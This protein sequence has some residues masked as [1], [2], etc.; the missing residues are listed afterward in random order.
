MSE[1]SLSVC[2]YCASSSKI[3]PSFLEQAH[4]LG[5]ALADR[6]WRLVY[7]AGSSGLMGQVADGALTKGGSVV[8]IIPRFMMELEWNHPH[9]GETVVT[10]T[11][12]ER[13]Q[14]MIDR[15]DAFVTLPGGTG[16]LEEVTECLSF[17]RLGLHNKPVALANWGGYYD[18]LIEQLNRTIDD[19]FLAEGF[20]GMFE[21]FSDLE[22][23]LAFLESPTP[24]TNPIH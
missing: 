19:G 14:I 8:G 1:P 13:K 17:K 21:S 16:T 11:M 2:V 6:Q 4:R 9:I 18:P 24:W 3:E 20:R 23:L 15:A 7:G 10:T 12:H 22:G 5:E